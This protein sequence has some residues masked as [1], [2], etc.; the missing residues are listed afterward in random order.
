VFVS[1]IGVGV[2]LL[3]IG[4]FSPL[5]PTRVVGETEQ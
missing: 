1:F 5:P 3:L 4:Y 2:M